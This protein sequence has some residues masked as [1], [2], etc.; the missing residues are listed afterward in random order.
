MSRDTSNPRHRSMPP[1]GTLR[2]RGTTQGRVRAMTKRATFGFVAALLVVM[3][4]AT[5]VLFAVQQQQHRMVMGG[6]FTMED[7]DGKPV[8]QADLLGKP[9]ALFF[10]FAGCPDTCPTILLALTD[11]M[12]DMGA[13]ADRLNVVFVTIDPSR[14][15]PDVLRAYLSSFDPRIRGFT[16]T[17]DQVAAMASAYHVAYRRVPLEG[18]GYTMDHSAAVLLFD[19]AGRFAGGLPFGDDDAKMRSQLTALVDAGT[20]EASARPTAGSRPAAAN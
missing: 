7:M 10:G 17:A 20:K 4:M 11:A 19:R 15:T 8:T 14:D 1:T 9:S 16:G 13:E 3:F 6:P 2:E 5:G 12:R 18:G